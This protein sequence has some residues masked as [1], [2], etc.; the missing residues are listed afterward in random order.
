MDSVIINFEKLK[1]EYERNI[2]LQKEQLIQDCKNEINQNEEQI[3]ALVLQINQLQENI[4][5]NTKLIEKLEQQKPIK[6]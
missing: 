5:F 6:N 4:D 3:H 1:Q 2:C